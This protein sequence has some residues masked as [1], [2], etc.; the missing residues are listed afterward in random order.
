MT[1]SAIF[2][3]PLA[4]KWRLDW[5]VWEEVKSRLEG[6]CNDPGEGLVSPPFYFPLSFPNKTSTV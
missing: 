2:N 4:A 6:Y 3:A 1:C 5:R